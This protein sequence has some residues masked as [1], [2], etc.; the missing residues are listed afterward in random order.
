MGGERG[1]GACDGASGLEDD[2]EAG[3]EATLV[4]SRSQ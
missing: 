2:V 1:M 4:S 3:A